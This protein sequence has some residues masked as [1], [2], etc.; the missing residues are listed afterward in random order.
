MSSQGSMGRGETGPDGVTRLR[1]IDAGG[2]AGPDTTWADA[3]PA[4]T[5]DTVIRELADL[6][7]AIRHAFVDDLPLMRAAEA[8]AALR[9]LNPA[10]AAGPAFVWS[11]DVVRRL[12]D[13]RQRIHQHLMSHSRDY[14]ILV[15]I[16]TSKIEYCDTVLRELTRRL[17]VN[18]FYEV[19]LHL[20]E[21]RAQI[22]KTVHGSGR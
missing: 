10:L 7:I 18:P 1:R 11:E 9:P 19:L 13:L 8:L 12:A 5:V 17:S 16:R 14:S 15:S 2:Q 4:L 20:D 3:R 6:R 21:A 22:A